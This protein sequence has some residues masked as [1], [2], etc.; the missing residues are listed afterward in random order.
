MRS[1]PATR[2]WRHPAEQHDEREDSA[3][4][5]PASAGVDQ[6]ADGR[7]ER[8]QHDRLFGVEPIGGL[9][10]GDVPGE[11]RAGGIDECD[12]PPRR[13]RLCVEAQHGVYAVDVEQQAVSV[14][15]RRRVRPR[16]ERRRGVGATEQ[17][18]ERPR[19][20]HARIF[21]P[22]RP[23]QFGRR[24]VALQVEGVGDR[25]LPGQ[26]GPVGPQRRGTSQLGGPRVH[27]H[28]ARGGA[29]FQVP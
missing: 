24:R 15:D 12:R 13:G 3:R 10:R 9:L 18:R 8:S 28:L 25:D 19:G 21:Q 11:Q 14:V 29:S 6:A 26:I 4:Q 1:A 2:I 27:Q 23:T 22:E 5:L 17:Q 7:A 20:V 16:R